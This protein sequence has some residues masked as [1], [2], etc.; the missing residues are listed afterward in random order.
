M[1]KLLTIA[2]AA[3]ILLGSIYPL[4]IAFAT[5]LPED[6]ANLM[7]P[8]PVFACSPQDTKGAVVGNTERQACPTDRCF[9]VEEQPTKDVVAFAATSSEVKGA[10]TTPS[11][12]TRLAT[13]SAVMTKTPRLEV[14]D[15]IATT[16]ATVVLRA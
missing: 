10:S 16:I 2:F 12:S 1:G 3:N 6:P 9:E 7:T 8:V 5:P 13:V 15:L 14:R 11:T 4:Q